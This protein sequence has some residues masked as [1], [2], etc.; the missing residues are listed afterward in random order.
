M[1]SQLRLQ[2]LLPVAVLGILGLGVG[3][4]ATTRNAPST[5]DADAIAARIAAKRG[6]T[7]TST[8]PAKPKPPEQTAPKL[9]PLE[10]QLRAHRIVVVL[11]YAPGDDYDT[12]Q[13][14]ET[15]AGALAVKAGFLALNVKKNNQIAALAAQ[16][17][18]R[19]APATVI[20]LP[21]PR[22]FYRVAG[23]MDRAAIAQAAANARV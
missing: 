23:Y 9:T 4:F 19:D 6:Q 20:F 10:R 1:A 8:T 18:I 16:Y 7:T 11:F 22:V 13:T 2:V 3:A 14:R 17:D 15:R 12:I 21:G 5:S